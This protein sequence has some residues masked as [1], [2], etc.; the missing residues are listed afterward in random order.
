MQD[1]LQTLVVML[2]SMFIGAVLEYNTGFYTKIVNKMANLFSE[3]W[4]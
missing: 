1:L 3:L 2:I 4:N